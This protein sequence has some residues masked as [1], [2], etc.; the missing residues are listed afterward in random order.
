LKFLKHLKNSI[1][2]VHIYETYISKHVYNKYWSTQCNWHFHIL[3]VTLCLE[4]SSASLQVICKIYNR[5]LW[6][7]AT[8]L[9]CRALK[10]GTEYCFCTHYPTS[11]SPPR[12]PGQPLVVTVLPSDQLL[13]KTFKSERKTGCICASVS[14]YLCYKIFKLPAKLLF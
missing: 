6:T 8:P 3:M 1:I 10:H 11:L 12:Y 4:F 5:L 14:N 2:I 9:C 13:L 7:M